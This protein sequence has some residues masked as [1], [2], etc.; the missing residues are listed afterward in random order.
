[1][2]MFAVFLALVIMFATTASGQQGFGTA[3]DGPESAK[4]AAAYD[5]TKATVI[6]AADVA[7]AIAKF[8]QD[9]VSV[10]GTFVERQDGDK[11][12]YRVAVD[13]RR[14]PQRANAHAGEAE[15]WSVVDGSGTITTGG[16]IVDTMQDGK[17]VG[18]EIEGGISQKVTKGDFVVIPEGVPHYITEA[19]PHVI[20]V[21]IEFPRPPAAPRP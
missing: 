1:M 2:R 16:K 10:N 19:N 5:P 20:F 4:L 3:P 9:R 15:I 7:A 11:F 14:T 12:G 18:R 21:A 17:V 6:T 13:R 8:P